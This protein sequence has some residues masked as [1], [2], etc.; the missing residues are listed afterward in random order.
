M[1]LYAQLSLESK[2]LPPAQI[3]E[4]LDFVHFLRLKRTLDSGQT[5]FWT[6]KWQFK[7]KTIERDRKHGRVIG[8]GSMKGLISALGE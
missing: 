8:D 1:S 7:E 4:V 5:Y 3:R 6:K 2:K